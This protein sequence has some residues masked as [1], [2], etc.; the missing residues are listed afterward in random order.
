MWTVF[1]IAISL[2]N[3]PATF[4]LTGS[5]FFIQLYRLEQKWIIII[6]MH[7]KNKVV[8]PCQFIICSFLPFY[9]TK[10]VSLDSI[11]N[12]NNAPFCCW[13]FVS[14][15]ALASA[16]PWYSGFFLLGL[17]HC[18]ESWLFPSF[19][20]ACPM[21]I[22]SNLLGYF[23]G[24]FKRKKKHIGLKKEGEKKLAV[25]HTKSQAETCRSSNKKR[26]IG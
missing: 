1:A 5:L 18:W 15:V 23:W 10:G 19:H 17:S 26:R 24:E 9:V 25:A 13:Q 11:R 22:S 4:T 12:N 21:A 7:H 6:T 3:D 2:I 8:F 16:K 20:Y 14:R